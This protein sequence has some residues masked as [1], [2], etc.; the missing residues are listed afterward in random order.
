MNQDNSDLNHLA[1]S[2]IADWEL[3]HP[4]NERPEASDSVDKVSH[5][6]IDEEHDALWK[7]ILATYRKPMSPRVFAILAA[8][9]LEDLLASF[10][11]EYIDRVETLARQDPKFK[12]LLGGVWKNAITDDVWERLGRVR[13]STW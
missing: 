5:F 1:E 4:D 7:F 11:P 6:H 12:E 13:G 8:G 10:G 9:P 2:W 3:R